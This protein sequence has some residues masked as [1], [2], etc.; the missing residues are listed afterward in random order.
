MIL[1]YMRTG[2]FDHFP[3]NPYHLKRIKRDAQFFNMR[4]LVNTFFN[5]YRYP[6]E[7]CFILYFLFRLKIWNASITK[8]FF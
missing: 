1:E 8:Y 5:K 3:H 7:V 4:E 2:S 6:I